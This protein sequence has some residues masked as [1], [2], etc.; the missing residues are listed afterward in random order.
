[1]SESQ[2]TQPYTPPA[3]DISAP[4]MDE[5]YMPSL[6]SL[7]GRI[8]RL[9]FFAYNFICYFVIGIVLVLLGVSAGAGSI[10]PD[11]LNNNLAFL[12]PVYVVVFAISFILSRRRL[13]DLDLSAWW[14]LLYIVPIANIFFSLF[15][16]AKSGTQGVN[17]FGPRPS[18]NTTLLWVFGAICLLLAVGTVVIFALNFQQFVEA[19]A[20]AASS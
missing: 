5:E 7:S 18:K 11:A 2:T 9:R 3:A 8:G 4:G 1:M 20:G 16:S 10:D 15:V 19:Q 6:F 17:R 13:H 14:F 12:V